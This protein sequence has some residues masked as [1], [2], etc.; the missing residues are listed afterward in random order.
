MPSLEAPPPQA[1]RRRERR[2]TLVAALV[3]A[4]ALVCAVL[5]VNRLRR[6]AP[7][8]VAARADHGPLPRAVREQAMAILDRH[9]LDATMVE[10]LRGP[11]REFHVRGRSRAP[12]AQEFNA[13]FKPAVVDGLMPLLRPYGEIISFDI[14]SLDLPPARLRP[15]PKD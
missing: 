8:P 13:G 2:W 6:I 5:A 14:A 3:G 9:L 15:L 10:V 12:L 1:D 11:V 4:A 7:A